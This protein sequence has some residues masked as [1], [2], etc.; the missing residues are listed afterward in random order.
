MPASFHPE[1]E[2]KFLNL[3]E[4]EEYAKGFGQLV[5]HLMEPAIPIMWPI[6]YWKDKLPTNRN[7]HNQNPRSAIVLCIVGIFISISRFPYIQV[8][9]LEG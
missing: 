5:A 3:S 1:V 7:I 8:S 6:L 9:H 2:P 4:G